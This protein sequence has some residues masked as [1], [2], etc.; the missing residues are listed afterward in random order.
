MSYPKNPTVCQKFL[1]HFNFRKKTTRSCKNRQ[2][3]N[4]ETTFR[5]PSPRLNVGK[6]KDFSLIIEIFTCLLNYV[7]IQCNAKINV[8]SVFID[9]RLSNIE[10]GGRGMK[11]VVFPIRKR[12]K[13]CFFLWRCLTSLTGAR[14]IWSTLSNHSFI[15]VHVFSIWKILE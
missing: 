8:A 3:S 5:T 2:F 11:I 14:N 6:R 13:P 4:K 9:R 15:L 10:L 7:T 12:G 1:H